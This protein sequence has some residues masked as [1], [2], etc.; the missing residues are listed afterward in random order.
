M[1]NE[2]EILGHRGV[3]GDRAFRENS[4]SAFRHALKYADGLETDAVNSKDGVPFLI[5]DTRTMFIP[6][7]HTWVKKLPVSHPA[8]MNAAALDA[9]GIMRLSD[10]FAVAV[11]EGIGKTLNIELKG[12]DTAQSVIDLIH[13]LERRGLN[14]DKII[15]SSF[16]HPEIVKARCLDPSIKRGLIFWQDSIRPSAYYPWDENCKGRNEPIGIEYLKSQA[17]HDAAPDYIVMPAGGLKRKYA[18]AVRGLFPETSFIVWTAGGENPPEN[19][20][21]LLDKLND[22][23]TGPAIGAVITNYPREMKEFIR[24]L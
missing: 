13:D 22:P 19:N 9:A 23:V 3:R 15:L 5:H 20:A 12:P 10:L 21:V 11:C 1:S 8:E 17:V 14:K 2:V 4:L 7:V 24:T 6:Y 16:N 18:E